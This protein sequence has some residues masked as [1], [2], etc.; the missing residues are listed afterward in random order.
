MIP[1][2]F[3]C[4]VIV[5]AIGWGGNPQR[6]LVLL[7]HRQLRL[8]VT[9]KIWD[10][11]ERRVPRILRNRKPG[12]NARPMLDWLLTVAHFVEPAP[13]GKQRSRDIADDPYLECALAAG[14]RF[15]VTNDRDLLDLEKP[16]GISIVTPVQVLLEVRRASAI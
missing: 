14:A 6:C 3:D 2:V 7:A 4:G 9:R 12:V 16:F 1:V 8:Y 13:L 11:Y 10:E 15:L 5:S